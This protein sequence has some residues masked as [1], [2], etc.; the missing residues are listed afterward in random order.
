[1]SVGA[2][3]LRQAPGYAEPRRHR[4]TGKQLFGI[5]SAFSLVSFFVGCIFMALIFNK[6]V[7]VVNAI[8]SV[9]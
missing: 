7:E 9:F 5:I 3:R 2:K 1:M 8:L 6:M 4:F